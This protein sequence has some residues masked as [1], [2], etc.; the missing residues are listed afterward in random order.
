MSENA[1][2][3]RCV[4]HLHFLAQIR[5][6]GFSAFFGIK[7]R[8]PGSGRNRSGCEGIFPGTSAPA[9]QLEPPSSGPLFGAKSRLR[10]AATSKTRRREV[11]YP[12]KQVV[13]ETLGSAFLDFSI[14]LGDSQIRR[15]SL[16]P[17]PGWPTCIPEFRTPFSAGTSPETGDSDVGKRGAAKCCTR[18]TLFRRN[19]KIRIL[20]IPR[21]FFKANRKCAANPETGRVAVRSLP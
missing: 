3:R 19:L 5:V 1:V 9:G 21:T 16:E 14:R 8:T 10:R 2:P 13:A 20:Q 4:S 17:R 12:R 7:P 18:P 15:L 11:G 6:G